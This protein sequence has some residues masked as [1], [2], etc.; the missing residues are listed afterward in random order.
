[1]SPWYPAQRRHSLRFHSRTKQA[2]ET[3][4]G[5][6]RYIVRSPFTSTPPSP[7]PNTS[8]FFSSTLLIQC[9]WLMGSARAPLPLLRARREWGS[10]LRE[11]PC[12][13]FLLSGL[14]RPGRP[15]ADGEGAA[16]ALPKG[17]FRSPPSAKASGGSF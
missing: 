6:S 16:T 8:T 1:M 11:A 5:Q 2:E 14:A 12:H 3:R 13:R 17:C 4:T 9:R 15:C 10:S 7:A